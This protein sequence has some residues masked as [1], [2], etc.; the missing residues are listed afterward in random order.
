MP[1]FGWPGPVIRNARMGSVFDHPAMPLSG[2]VRR[3]SIAGVRPFVM[4]SQ[5][6]KPPVRSMCPVPPCLV[7]NSPLNCCRADP[8]GAAKDH[9]ALR[10]GSGSQTCAGTD[11][12]SLRPRSGVG[13]RTGPRPHKPQPDAP[14]K[15]AKRPAQ[16]VQGGGYFVRSSVLFP[17]LHVA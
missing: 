13:A 8:T 10:P 6:Q 17:G 5:Q 12:R 4:A 1:V 15:R 9:P 2:C 16:K 11:I 7:G 3:S 14:K